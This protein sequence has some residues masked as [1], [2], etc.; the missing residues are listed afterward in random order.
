MVDAVRDGATGFV[1]TTT[2][3]AVAALTALL[4]PDTRYRMSRSA[5]EFS[6]EFTAEAIGRQLRELGLAGG[7]RVSREVK[8]KAEVPADDQT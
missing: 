3:E 2:D 1:V 5:L 6:R 7:E 8:S 4:D